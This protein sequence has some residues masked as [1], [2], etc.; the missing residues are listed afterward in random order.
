MNVYLFSCYFH[1]D[2]NVTP[3]FNRIR[4]GGVGPLSEI[5]REYIRE[6]AIRTS[7]CF[8]QPN[9]ARSN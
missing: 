4:F 7:Q 9:C 2:A 3:S 5:C 6:T 8:F 1:L